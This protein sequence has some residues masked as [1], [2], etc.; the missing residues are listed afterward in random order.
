MLKLGKFNK[1]AKELLESSFKNIYERDENGRT[2]LHYAVE[3]K[4]VELLV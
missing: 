1:S 4:T 3:V 2:A